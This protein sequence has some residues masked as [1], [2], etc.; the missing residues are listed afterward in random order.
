MR[1]VKVARV[2]LKD[3]R[4]VLQKLNVVGGHR[5]TQLAQLGMA[6]LPASF[7]PVHTVLSADSEGAASAGAA[8]SPTI[9]RCNGRVVLNGKQG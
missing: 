9:E 5:R 3:N 4:G 7:P 8:A 6:A 2:A 1:Q